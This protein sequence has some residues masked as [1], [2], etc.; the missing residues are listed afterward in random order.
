MDKDRKLIRIDK[1]NFS[2]KE[3]YI[4]SDG[5]TIW[6]ITN[7]RNNKKFI[8]HS[9]AFGKM[10][11]TFFKGEM[12]STKCA[13]EALRQLCEILIE[14]NLNPHI[15]IYYKNTSLIKLCCSIGFR[16]TPGIKHTYYLKKLK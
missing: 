10:Y 16:K 5:D 9:T 3:L 1:E 14:R 7:P 13:K 6:E 4:D 12:V 2:L 8:V 15:N 11:I